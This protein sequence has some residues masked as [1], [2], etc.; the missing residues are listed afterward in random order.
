[1]DNIII[2]NLSY[3]LV[4]FVF[5][6]IFGRIFEISIYF[7]KKRKFVNRSIFEGPYFPTYGAGAIFVLIISTL[8]INLFSKI[9]LFALSTAMVEFAVG[10]FLIL[11][12][13]VIWKYP[14]KEHPYN[15]KRIISVKSSLTWLVLSLLF[16]FFVYPYFFIFVHN[17]YIVVYFSIIMACV[18]L[19]E[20]LLYK[21]NSFRHKS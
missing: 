21:I 20:F 3:L 10:Y 15:Y 18:I 11:R 12:K 14:L 19:G 1:M 4:V 9:L 7:F 5:A 6:S 8:E 2:N 16:Y 13:K 17:F